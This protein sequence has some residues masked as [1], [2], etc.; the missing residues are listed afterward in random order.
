[1]MII[2]VEGFLRGGRR[3]AEV[4]QRLSAHLVFASLGMSSWMRV[5]PHS[6]LV[7]FD[8]FPVNAR[9]YA[10]RM[11]RCDR[12]SSRL[13]SVDKHFEAISSFDSRDMSPKS[14]GHHLRRQPGGTEANDIKFVL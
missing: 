1:M 12:R 8:A 11:L 10:V 14:S 9:T 7:K 3:M 13:I 2:D 6:F 4:L 5:D